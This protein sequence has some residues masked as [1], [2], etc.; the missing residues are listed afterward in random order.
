[1]LP[2][3]SAAIAMASPWSSIATA[4][5]ATALPVVTTSDGPNAAL[6]LPDAVA[7]ITLPAKIAPDKTR[8][9]FA[10]RIADTRRRSKLRPRTT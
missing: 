1:M 10:D 4:G 5:D 9:S 3:P 6:A 2:V 8:W 7:A